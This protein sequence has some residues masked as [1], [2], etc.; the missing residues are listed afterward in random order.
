V[1][2]LGRPEPVA[3]WRAGGQGDRRRRPLVFVANVVDVP[4]DQWRA[5][6]RPV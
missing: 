3:V 1:D 6:D 2:A 4:V 5:G